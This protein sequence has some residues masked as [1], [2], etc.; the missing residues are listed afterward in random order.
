MFRVLAVLMSVLCISVY[1]S[2]GVCQG[3][4]PGEVY[5]IGDSNWTVVVTLVGTDISTVGV[6]MLRGKMLSTSSP[7]IGQRGNGREFR[8]VF[9]RLRVSTATPRTRRFPAVR[10]QRPV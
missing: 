8:R 6:S 5:D 2:V 4:P 7:M 1:G 3:S 9:R 10:L